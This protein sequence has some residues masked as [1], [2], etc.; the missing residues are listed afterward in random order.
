[1]HTLCVP[2]R[3]LGLQG[4]LE[5]LIHNIQN[6]VWQGTVSHLESQTGTCVWPSAAGFWGPENRAD[7]GHLEK[8]V[9]ILTTS[10]ATPGC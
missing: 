6:P 8:E 10:P 7:A 2:P 9:N 3:E 4:L 1:M 5:V